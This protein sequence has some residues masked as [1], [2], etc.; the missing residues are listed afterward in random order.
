MTK[1]TKLH[2][3]RGEQR[4]ALTVFPIRHERTEGPVLDLADDRAL[5]VGEL[6]TPSVPHLQVTAGDA[7]PVLLLDGT[8]LKRGLQDRIA[9]DSSLLAPGTTMPVDVRGRVL[10][11]SVINYASAN[12]AVEQ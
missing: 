7:V 6:A 10:H 9:M 1:L 2:V 8:L 5:R 12:G 11:A 3:G 4:G